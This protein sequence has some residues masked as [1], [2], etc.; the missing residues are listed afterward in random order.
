MESAEAAVPLSNVTIANRVMILQQT[1]GWS[2]TMLFRITS[3]SQ[4][5]SP[6]RVHHVLAQQ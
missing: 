4:Q 3:F 2:D 5:D 6:A 1:N